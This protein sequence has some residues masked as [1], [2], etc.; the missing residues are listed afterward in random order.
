MKKLEMLLFLCLFSLFILTLYGENKENITV[1][2]ITDNVFKIQFTAPFMTNSYVFSTDEGLILID[3]GFADSADE[4]LQ[5][6]E[7]FSKKVLYVL[8]THFHDDH[9]GAHSKFRGKSTI[10]AH[11]NVIKHLCNYYSLPPMKHSSAPDLTFEEEMILYVSG[12]QIIIKHLQPG[13]TDSGLSVYI[14]S[15]KVLLTGDIIGPENF[16]YCD[17]NGGGSVKGMLANYQ[18]L[19]NNYPDDTIYLSGHGKPYTKTELINYSNE[20]DEHYVICTKLIKG[21]M[22]LDGLK[23][24][25][26]LQKF[27]HLTKIFAGLKMR[28]LTAILNEMRANPLESINKPVTKK[29]ANSGIDAAIEEYKHLKT[30]DATKYNFSE[31][32]LNVLGYELLKRKMITEA[33]KIFELNAAEFP[34]SWNAY[35][36]LAEAYLNAGDNENAIKFYSKSLELNPENN[37]A[38]QQIEKLKKN[39]D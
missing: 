23:T 35:D 5:K 39:P 19:I 10:I 34:E 27:E 14:P 21:G 9:L 17:I 32:E 11:S 29:I 15:E 31:N 12:K 13:D 6:I 26:E 24:A 28:W 25:P 22:D 20:L 4:Y 3:T 1:E 33:V 37:N 36:S 2:K 8:T 7:K 18:E 38:K 16:P 30:S